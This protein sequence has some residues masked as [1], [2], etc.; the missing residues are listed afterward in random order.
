VVFKSKVDGWLAAVLL[1]VAFLPILM[2]GGAIIFG[3]IGG[4]DAVVI[5]VALSFP[6]LL[7]LW[8][9]FGTFYFLDKELLVVRAG[10]VRLDVLLSSI[11]SIAPVRSMVAAPALSTDRVEI[12]YG[13]Y[14]RLLI[15]PENRDA[16]LASLRACA[17]QAAHA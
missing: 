16:F 17:P 1:G 2:I 13:D 10:P 8:M 6:S 14:K 11:K 7:I 12:V 9:F 4:R 5:G 3:A 15:S